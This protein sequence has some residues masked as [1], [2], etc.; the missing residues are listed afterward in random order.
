MIRSEVDDLEA[1]LERRKVVEEEL[2]QQLAVT[3]EALHRAVDV[4]RASEGRARR[5]EGDVARCDDY[6]GRDLDSGVNAAGLAER[7]AFRTRLVEALTTA[8][9]ALEDS[10]AA[11]AEAGSAH[12]VAQKNLANAA[13]RRVAVEKALSDARRS[14]QRRADDRLEEEVADLI[15]SRRTEEESSC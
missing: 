5:C 1:I 14:A 11:S 15:A 10:R 3:T 4:E 12:K 8:R 7:A 13:A 2:S 9:Q 6:G